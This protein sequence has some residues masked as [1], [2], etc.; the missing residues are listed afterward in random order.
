[1]PNKH[2][3]SENIYI[4]TLPRSGATLLG[5]ILGSHSQIFHMGESFYWGK[6]NPKD[7][8]CSCGK[9]DCLFLNKIYRQAVKHP[10]ITE[11]YNTSCM[12][13]L[14]E[15]PNKI[16]HK[17]SLLSEDQKIQMMVGKNLDNYLN[18]SCDGLEKLADIFRF[19]SGKKIMVDN[20]KLIRI[21]EHLVKRKN[22][23]IILLTRDPRGLAYSN[24]K[25]GI[26]KNVSRPLEN[27]IPVY[28]EFAKRATKLLKK[29]RVFFMKYENLCKNPEKEIPDLC[30]FIGINFEPS[31]LKF[32]VDKGH[33]LMGNRMRFDN[34]QKI[35]EDLDWIHGL[36]AKEKALIVKNDILRKLYA[37][38]GY[39]LAGE[40]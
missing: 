20:S 1:M 2:S 17:L 31:M 30:K 29:K 32:K 28:I 24:K 19:V 9:F 3:S 22:W 37:N 23:K 11:I 25:S 7:V 12:I 4:A 16:Y 34:N 6:L 36:D 13:D 26:R 18:K 15:E 33:T 21:A 10:E 39:A 38:L 8:K 40:P 35:K 14:L 27:K 5:M